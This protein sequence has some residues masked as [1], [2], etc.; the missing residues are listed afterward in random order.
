MLNPLELA[1]NIA[2]KMPGWKY[3]AWPIAKNF[4][5]GRTLKEGLEKARELSR[6]GYPVILNYAGEHAHNRKAVVQTCSAYSELLDELRRAQ[7]HGENLTASVSLKLSQFGILEAD[8]NSSINDEFYEVLEKA[9][10]QN[11][12]VWIDAEEPEYASKYFDFL[13]T[14]WDA[15]FRNIG[16]VVQANIRSENWEKFCFRLAKRP[17]PTRI[18]KGAYRKENPLTL[19]FERELP[20][21]LWQFRRMIRVLVNHKIEVEIAT[22]ET[23]IQNFFAGSPYTHPAILYGVNTELARALKGMGH[24]PHIYL[25]YG[26]EWAGYVKRRLLENPKYLLL[27]L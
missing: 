2:V 15:G 9:E 21:I 24:P 14:L 4:I 8:L 7:L 5:A 17:I 3:W 11:I 22:H 10:G 1:A 6:D 23:D 12:R 19:S 20:E 13:D 25:I 26:P 16:R 18:C 27:S